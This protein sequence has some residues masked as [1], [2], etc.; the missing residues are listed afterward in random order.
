MCKGADSV[1]AEFLTTKSLDTEH[2]QTQ[3]I[4]DQFAR[5]GLRTLYLAER[6]IPEAE[7][8]AWKIGRAHV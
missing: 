3:P 7:Y 6:Y 8:E 1:I 4:V 2:Q 5:L